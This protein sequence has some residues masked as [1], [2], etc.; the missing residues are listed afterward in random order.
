MTRTERNYKAITVAASDFKEKD[1]TVRALTDCGLKTFVL[2][3]VKG[4]KA[5]LKFAASL[6]STVEFF[7]IGDGMLTVSGASPV[8]MRYGIAEDVKKY[9]AASVVA[10]AVSK[11]CG[12]EGDTAAEFALLDFALSAI[13][14]GE[15]NPL[16]VVLWTLVKLFGVEGV[17]FEDYT[18][19]RGVKTLFRALRDADFTDL[20]ALD[21]EKA[22]YLN[23][24]R[25]AELLLNH[26]LGIK[27][28]SLS[29]A[30]GVL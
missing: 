4:D 23:A 22:D 6:F 30:E 21:F 15:S 2:K 18:V 11:C 16:A 7:A 25:F 13:D 27:L 5:K 24:A 14:A 20:D 8:D 29:A 1:K 9:A 10:E 28:R 17:D 12:E 19:S 3:G 26:A